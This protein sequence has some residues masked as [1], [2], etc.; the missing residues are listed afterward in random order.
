[1]RRYQAIAF[2][3]AYL[4]AGN[5]AD[6]EEAA[7]SAF[8]KAYYALP[9]FRS[10]APFRPWLL[11]IAANEAKNRRRSAGRAEGLRVR[12][13]EN[14]PR[15]DAAPSPEGA[16]L[17]RADRERLLTELSALKERDRMVIT[18]RYLLDLSEEETARV[19]GCSRGT[20]K[21]RLHR[22]LQRLQ[23]RLVEVETPAGGE[24]A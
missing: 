3:T 23:A 5:A 1:M 10:G 16:V 15:D 8:T 12:L 19:L 7:Q 17:A 9:R 20:V 24:G 11:R 2:R 4:V 6:A 18:Y 13:V 14:R 22:A 21:S